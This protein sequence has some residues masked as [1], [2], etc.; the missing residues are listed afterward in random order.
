MMGMFYAI[1]AIIAAFVCVLDL[2]EGIVYAAMP[3]PPLKA[4]F[5][6]RDITPEIGMEV[7]GGYG[8]AYARVIHDPCKVRA[9][10]FDDGKTRVAIVGID[11][12]MIRKPTVDAVRKAIHER[13]GIAPHAVLIGASH[14]H[15]SGPTG[16]ILPGEFDDASPL[17]RSLA[18]EKSS[19]ADAKYLALVEKQIVEAVAAADAGRVEAFCGAGNGIEDKAAFNRRFKMKNGLCYT[20]P[21]QGNPEIVA[22]AGPTDPNVGV[23][24]AWNK[25]GKLLGCVVNYCCHGTTGPS[26]ISANWIYYLE[27]TIRGMF[28]PDTVVV[29][30]QGASGDVTQ[31]DNL[32]PFV[33]PGQERW[34]EIVGGRVG[35]EAVKVLV[36][37]DRGTLVPVAAKTETLKLGR[38]KPSP[39]RVKK[40][41]AIAQQPPEKVEHTE[42]TFAKEIVLLD[43]ILA[44][45]P[46]REFEVQAIQVGPVVILANPAEFFCQLGLDIRAKS[47]FPITFVV[48]LA[49]DC[50]GYVPTEEALGPHG[51]GYETR[52]TAYSNLEPAA[53]PKIVEACARLAGQLQPGEVPKAPKAPPFKAPWSYGNVPPE[54]E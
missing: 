7:P 21:G 45:E 23:I 29:F 12:L 41:L 27:K 52:L 24:G 16:M 30:L 49:N 33:Q 53:G 40:C 38:R 19:C 37:M 1:A 25:E 42:W 32:N 54:L 6:E 28:S 13:T 5:A 36:S 43:A 31:V 15:S 50:V 51:G 3:A 11:A 8:K 39:E 26:G 9:A 46:V 20:H 10:V 22:P 34:A 4:G 18:Y 47:R 35:A 17:V 2:G 48:E 44:K 14:S